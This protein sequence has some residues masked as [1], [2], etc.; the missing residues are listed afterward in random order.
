MNRFTSTIAAI[1]LLATI[2][3]GGSSNAPSSTTT[4]SAVALAS[5]NLA[6]GSTVQGTVTLSAAPSGG[7]T[8]SLVSSNTAVATVPATVTIAAGASSATFTVTAVAPGSAS[9]TASMNGANS[10]SAALTVIG[11][12]VALTSIS[13]A[14]GT[15]VGGNQLT[16]TLTLTGAAPTGGASVTLTATDPIT[17][18]ASVL[19]PAGAT[20]ATFSASTRAVAGT[21]S[22][23]VTGSYGGGSATA[24]LSVTKPTTAIASFGVTG[25]TETDT[26]TITNG[27]NTLN[28][29]LNGSTSAA[30]GTITAYDWTYTPAGGKTF[31]QTTTGAVLVQPTVNCTFLPAPPLAA[32]AEQWL[33]LTVTLVVHDNLGNVSP[34]A[35]DKGARVF[36][37]G[38]CGF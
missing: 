8:I 22:G 16:G 4:I 15:V 12:A 28:C 1:A 9:I 29:T 17:V 23:T 13:F 38:S 25:P 33:A 18:P 31:S 11:G 20:T 7:A 37:Q 10:Q 6:A 26:C 3:C 21:I 19:V 14:S 30:P 32:G 36:P 35:T 5:S 24:T 27:G 2:Q 34:V